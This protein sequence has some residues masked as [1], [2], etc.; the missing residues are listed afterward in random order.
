MDSCFSE[1]RHSITSLF[2]PSHIPQVTREPW[3]LW[4]SAAELNDWD[5]SVLEWSGPCSSES[6]RWDKLA[7]HFMGTTIPNPSLVGSLLK[8]KKY[9]SFVQVCKR[10]KC[11]GRSKPLDGGEVY[12][13]WK[14]K[15]TQCSAVL[16]ILD[17][18]LCQAV[19]SITSA[20][21]RRG[22]HSLL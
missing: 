15:A 1:P 6:G 2:W 3:H 9:F 19:Y 14:F 7:Q 17:T 10:I 13:E 12:M 11:Q 21:F 16:L 4:A 20:A 5:V 22:H 18:W 8:P